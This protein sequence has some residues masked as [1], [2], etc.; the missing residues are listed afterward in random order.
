MRPVQAHHVAV[1]RAAASRAV[2]TGGGVVAAATAGNNS[3]VSIHVSI[4]VCA[5]AGVSTWITWSSPSRGTARSPPQEPRLLAQVT[6]SLST[7]LDAIED[8]FC[9]N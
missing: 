4:H 7:T 8:K 2:A 5:A 3:H 1:R 6:V 9:D